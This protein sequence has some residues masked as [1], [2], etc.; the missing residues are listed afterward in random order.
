M[1]STSFVDVFRES[2]V[3]QTIVKKRAAQAFAERQTVV[4]ERVK[5]TAQLAVI[6][7]KHDPL[8]AA[9][10]QAARDARKKIDDAQTKYNAAIGRRDNALRAVE[11]V[12]RRLDRELLATVDPRIPAARTD[13]C[14]RHD[15]VRNRLGKTEQQQTGQ[16]NMAGS[17]KPVVKVSTNRPALN[18]LNVA[19]AAARGRFDELQLQNPN[20][21]DAAIVD[22]LADVTAAWGGIDEMTDCGTR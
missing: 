11:G 20:D 5:Q 6:R 14:A 3:G 9:A 16:F 19:I 13:M 21:V 18:R 22:V 7:K 4:D 8:V 17:G 15:R 12:I 2:T 10:D 1:T